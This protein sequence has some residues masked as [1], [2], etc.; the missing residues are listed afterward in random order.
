MDLLDP[1]FD[2][3][4][5]ELANWF[6]TQPQDL[7]QSPDYTVVYSPSQ[8]N[9][10]KWNKKGKNSQHFVFYKNVKV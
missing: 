5:D 4:T 2:V 8:I 10:I 3:E 1:Q 6:M 7:I 9:R